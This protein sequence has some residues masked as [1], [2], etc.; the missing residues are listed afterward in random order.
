MYVCV[1]PII[2]RGVHRATRTQLTQREMYLFMPL[3]HTELYTQSES[4]A[5]SVRARPRAH[6]QTV[7]HLLYMLK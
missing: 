1:R 2:L 5:A 3:S 6:T 7:A 4:A